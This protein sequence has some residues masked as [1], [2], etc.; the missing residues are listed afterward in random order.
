MADDR[1][2]VQNAADPR[3]VKNARRKAKQARELELAD[4]AAVLGTLNGRRLLMRV[5]GYCRMFEEVFDE[6]AHRTAFNAGARNVGLF[7]L[8]EITTADETAFF[9]MM[10]E[11][12]E[13]ERKDAEEAEALR[14]DST[15]EGADREN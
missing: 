2:L 12:R 6:S 9:L 5:L 8:S 4:L 10:Q 13:R 7:L 14:N 3:Q 1:P 11:K 15:T